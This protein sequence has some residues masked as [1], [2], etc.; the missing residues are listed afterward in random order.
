[1]SL[2]R[3]FA[4][5]FFSSMSAISFEITLT[6]VFSISL[7]YHFAFMVI[8]IAMLGLGLSGT[9][10]SLTPRL[11]KRELLGTY[12]I[13]LSI[14]II[15]GYIGTT[16]YSTGNHLHFELLY[17]GVYIDPA[18]YIKIDKCPGSYP[19]ALTAAFI[20]GI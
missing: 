10:L 5:I 8:S 14:A 7:W 12:A 1:M 19:K 15:I 3:L 6:R 2:L 17:N 4:G 9:V 11:K 16:G 20:R 13:G 18:P